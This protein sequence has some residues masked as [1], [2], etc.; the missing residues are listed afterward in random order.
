MTT[1]WQVAIRTDPGKPFFTSSKGSDFGSESAAIHAAKTLVK[2][3]EGKFPAQIQEITVLKAPYGTWWSE[4]EK[5]TFV[6]RLYSRDGLGAQEAN[7]KDLKRAAVALARRFNV[8]TEE[9]AA[10]IGNI[11]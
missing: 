8:T 4:F 2:Q 9:L 6:T 3:L 5:W 11:S 7:P 1:T 10:L